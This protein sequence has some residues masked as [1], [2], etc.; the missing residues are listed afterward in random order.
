M[1]PLSL[2]SSRTLQWH[3][4][5]RGGGRG[6]KG[7][8]LSPF[9]PA[10]H[11]IELH[12][13]DLLVLRF[14]REKLR[15][16]MASE[17]RSPTWSTYSSPPLWS[18]CLSQRRE[19]IATLPCLRPCAAAASPLFSTRSVFC[20]LVAK[21]DL[22]S[23]CAAWRRRGEQPWVWLFRSLH[24]FWAAVQRSLGRLDAARGSTPP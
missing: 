4:M 15:A 10:H 20:N 18:S 22:D 12:C 23:A 3:S 8:Q 9:P 21:D 5:S 16:R 6:G 1:S 7:R 2:L 14:L 13:A 17:R 24:I 11:L 19:F